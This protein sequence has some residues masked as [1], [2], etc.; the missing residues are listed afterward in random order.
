MHHTHTAH[1]CSSHV[2]TS[3]VCVTHVPGGCTFLGVVAFFLV[4]ALCCRLMFGPRHKRNPTQNSEKIIEPTSAPLNIEMTTASG[5]A[6][7]LPGATS[8]EV[9]IV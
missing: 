6:A 5:G 1:L 3:H 2:R 8:E 4:V 9:Q 7:A